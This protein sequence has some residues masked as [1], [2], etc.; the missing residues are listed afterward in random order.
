MSQQINL[1]NA[2]FQRKKNYTTTPVLVAG[3]GALVLVLVG[4]SALAKAQLAALETEAATV[5]SNLANLEKRKSSATAAFVAPRKS[6]TLQQELDQAS[7]QF[8]NLQQVAGILEQG[9]PGET[10]GYSAYFRAFARRGVD[11]LWL[12]GV[13]I[14]GSGDAIGLQGRALKAS[15]L[16]GYLSGL[17]SEAVLRGKSFGQLEMR[18]PKAEPK[19]EAA[20]AAPAAPRYVEFSLQSASAGERGKAERP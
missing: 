20:D 18:E 13:T 19:A 1:F 16:P 6:E 8:R 5:Q 7:A 4:V 15:L 11:G 3:I 14:Q 2:G 17:A 12:T 10:R 9:Q